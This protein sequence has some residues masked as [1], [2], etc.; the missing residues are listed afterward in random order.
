MSVARTPRQSDWTAPGRL[1]FASVWTALTVA[2]LSALLPIGAPASVSVGSAFNPA[3]T[4]VVLKAGPQSRFAIAPPVRD[5]VPTQPGGGDAV[6]PQLAAL[7][8]DCAVEPAA[9]VAAGTT[10]FSDA[11]YSCAWPRGPPA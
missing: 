1:F 11:R 7:P 9:P 5:D 4:G 8:A 2:L 6:L 3:T 10:P